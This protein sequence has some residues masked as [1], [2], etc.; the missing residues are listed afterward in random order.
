MLDH[1][2]PAHH[3]P[4]FNL[5]VCG[6]PLFLVRISHWLLIANGSTLALLKAAK[7][8]AFSLVSVCGLALHPCKCTACSVF[9]ACIHGLPHRTCARG[10]GG[11]VP[12]SCICMY[13][14]LL[15]TTGQG[16]FWR[17]C[18][19]LSFGHGLLLCEPPMA[20]T[21]PIQLE[22]WLTKVGYE[23]GK[24]QRCDDFLWE[25]S[26]HAWATLLP[27]VC[28]LHIIWGNCCPLTLARARQA[29]RAICRRRAGLCF[30]ERQQGKGS[31]TIDYGLHVSSSQDSQPWRSTS[32]AGSHHADCRHP[33][34]LCSFWRTH[35]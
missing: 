9:L 1:T 6:G 23:S 21:A 16:A 20:E 35:R 33:S 12:S 28:V 4:R 2:E 19:W 8:A 17:C 11:R 7:G 32:I 25:R 27:C 5:F 22:G 14:L 29:L 24:W 26:F 10:V 31:L 13:H 18:L 15:C 30:Q 34:D 3:L